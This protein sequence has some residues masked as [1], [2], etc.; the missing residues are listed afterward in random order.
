MVWTKN[1]PD[2]RK[3]H[4]IPSEP[5]IL[6]NT[7]T[8]LNDPVADIAKALDEFQKK[9]GLDIPIHV[10]AASGGFIAPFLNPDLVWDFRLPRVYSINY[11]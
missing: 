11:T 9:T 3:Y 10:D 2:E 1:S 6:G 5:P 8:G 7:Y 4:Y